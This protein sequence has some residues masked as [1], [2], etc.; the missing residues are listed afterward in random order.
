MLVADARRIEPLAENRGEEAQG[1]EPGIDRRRLGR[2]GGRGRIGRGGV[3]VPIA[4]SGA[5]IR[6]SDGIVRGVVLVFRDF[7]VHKEFERTLIR[8]KE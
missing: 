4:D 3:D 2:S 1:F 5:P 7:T 6:E 8:A